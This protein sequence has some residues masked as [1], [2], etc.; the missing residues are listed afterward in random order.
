MI[1]V[2]TIVILIVV[3]WITYYV[4]NKLVRTRLTEP[5]ISA[6]KGDPRYFMG[7]PWRPINDPTLSSRDSQFFLT[8]S[9]IPGKK[10]IVNLQEKNPWRSNYFFYRDSSIEDPNPDVVI[11]Q[12]SKLDYLKVKNDLTC[13]GP[14]APIRRLIG[15][16]QPFMYDKPRI[17]DFYEH[18]FYRDWRYAEQPVDIRFPVDPNKFCARNPVVYPCAKFYSKW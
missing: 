12:V 15:Q 2:G 16:Y 9:I 3:A 11:N 14:D 5:F 8:R 10:S 18:P 6:T 7:T 1:D 4:I 17:I 13:I